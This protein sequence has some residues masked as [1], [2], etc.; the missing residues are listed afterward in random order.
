MTRVHCHKCKSDTLHIEV[1]EGKT[2][3]ICANCGEIVMADVA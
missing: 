1:H 2:V 3:I